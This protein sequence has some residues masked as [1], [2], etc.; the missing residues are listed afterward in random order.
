MKLILLITIMAVFAQAETSTIKCVGQGLELKLNVQNVLTQSET[1]SAKL[2]DQSAQEVQT[3]EMSVLT[4][5]LKPGEYYSDKE[6]R[7]YQGYALD[8][9]LQLGF[10]VSQILDENQKFVRYDLNK[11]GKGQALLGQCQVE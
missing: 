1:V 4:Q 2:T 9:K 6:V 10:S 7:I 8:Q 3:I 5:I 11:F